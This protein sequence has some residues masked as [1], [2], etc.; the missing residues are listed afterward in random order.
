M[1][2]RG[3]P[4]TRASAAVGWTWGGDFSS[5]SDLMHLLGQRLLMSRQGST[6]TKRWRP[7][8]LEAVRWSYAFRFPTRIALVF[9]GARV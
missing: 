4:V 9:A 7:L 1:I 6:P 5:V 8:L 3:V 2:L